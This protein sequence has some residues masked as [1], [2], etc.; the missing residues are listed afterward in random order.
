M[1]QTFGFN[2]TLEDVKLLKRHTKCIYSSSSSYLVIKLLLKNCVFDM[3]MSNL[4]FG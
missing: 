3:K 1:G 4:Q 2:C